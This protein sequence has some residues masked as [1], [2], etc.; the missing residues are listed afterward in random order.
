MGCMQQRVC[1]RVHAIGASLHAAAGARHTVLISDQAYGVT[2]HFDTR[3][4]ERRS[5]VST[6]VERCADMASVSVSSHQPRT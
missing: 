4:H 2:V 3:V 6:H 5:H 1:E